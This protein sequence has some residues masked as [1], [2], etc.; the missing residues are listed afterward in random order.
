MITLTSRAQSIA[1]AGR[2]VVDAAVEAVF[3]RTLP[4]YARHLADPILRASRAT[5]E[6]P[7][8]LAALAS[9]ESDYG[10][11]LDASGRGDGGHGHGIF[12]VDDRSHATWIATGK[13]HDPYES[14]VYAARLLGQNRAYFSSGSAGGVTVPVGSY[15]HRSG[16]PA[17]SYPDPRPLRGSQL[18]WATLSAYNTGPLNAL[19]AVATGLD[20]DTTTTGADY[21]ANVLDRA[22]RLSAAADRLSAAV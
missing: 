5:G 18:E 8:V 13:W 7:F 10:R 17:G 21:G 22:A 2:A 14:A 1:N 4:T 11:A 3:P 16:V 12:Q 19:R 20:P 6:S 15:A 9:R